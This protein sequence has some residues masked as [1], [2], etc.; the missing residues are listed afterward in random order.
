MKARAVVV[1]ILLLAI[2]SILCLL[3][4]EVLVRVVY[5]IPIAGDRPY[6]RREGDIAKDKFRVYQKSENHYLG[7]EI[8][9]NIVREE[10]YMDTRI[11]TN[12]LGMRDREYTVAKPDG[13]FRIA[14]LGDSITFGFGVNQE[15]VYTEVLEDRLLSEGRKIEVMNFAVPGYSTLKEVEQYRYKVAEY[16]PDL[17]IIGYC[18]NDLIQNSIERK[19]FDEEYFP[20]WRHMYS[21]DYYGYVFGE[22]M[23]QYLGTPKIPMVK[24]STVEGDLALV[25][26]YI[27][28]EAPVVIVMFPFIDDFDGG[29]FKGRRRGVKRGSKKN[30]L[31]LLDLFDD[32]SA[33]EPEMLRLSERDKYHPNKLGHEVAANATYDYLFWEGLLPG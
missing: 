7:F 5:G 4:I 6:E 9:P 30:G 16:D 17:V 3:V 10:Y 8:R 23:S 2:V 1:N 28:S 11:L 14:V 27:A 19:D 32:Y 29:H 13:V 21:F 33:Y 24:R 22:L 20:L 15:E 31:Y 18:M 12:S 25:K 26:Y